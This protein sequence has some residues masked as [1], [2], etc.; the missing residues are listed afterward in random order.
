MG[1]GTIIVS[2]AGS[3]PTMSTV[4]SSVS[5]SHHTQQQQHH[6]HHQQPHPQVTVVASQTTTG[7]H[8]PQQQQQQ[9]Q[10]TANRTSVDN[11]KEKCRKFLTNLIELSKREPKSVERNVRTLIQE[12][13]DAHVE[14]EEFCERLERLL[15][16][17]PQP[18]LIGFL[19][20]RFNNSNLFDLFELDLIWFEY[21]LDPL[22]F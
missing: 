20:V 4:P 19:K 13:V 11:S 10:T 14:P 15:N 3:M 16:A 9:Q 21:N 2:S 12:L 18:C 1:A 17:S 8:H 22:I 6:Q 7:G 5:S